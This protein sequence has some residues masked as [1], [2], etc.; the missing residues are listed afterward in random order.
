M[1]GIVLAGGT[2]SRLWPSTTSVSK[3]LLPVYDKPMIYYPIATLMSLGVRDFL[4]VTTPKDAQ[5][6][7]SLLG[8][9]SKWG[10]GIQFA[11]QQEPK[12]IAQSLLIGSHFIDGGS[13]VL[14]LGDNI[15]HSA[16]FVERLIPFVGGGGATALAIRVMNP[17]RY[18]IVEVGSQGTVLSIE[19]KPASPRSNLAVPGL[20]FFD[21]S[22]SS[23]AA[24]L[25]PS[26][27]GELEITD[28]LSAYLEAGSLNIVQLPPDT[29]WL[30]AGTVDDLFSATE[31]V[32]AV[33][34]RHGAKVGCP[35]EIAWHNGWIDNQAL[36]LLGQRLLP[37][38][39]GEYLLRLAAP[40][41][42]EG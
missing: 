9:G 32:R 4:V 11:E 5:A 25:R 22:A 39:Y 31:Y 17:Q 14:I 37:S 12:G 8:D 21:E 10:I 42:P 7:R 20:Y 6:F 2:G 35:E 23:L 29:I 41:R 33:E 24:G 16:G 18:G 13:C 3:Q 27:R 15:F 38:A 30:D 26:A 40:S 34:R 28:L 19:E 36:R 1:K